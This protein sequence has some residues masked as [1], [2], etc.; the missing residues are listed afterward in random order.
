MHKSFFRILVALGALIGCATIVAQSP[1]VTASGAATPL[2][3]KALP[4]IPGKEVT[5]LTV[6]YPPGGASPAHRH[7]A[8]VFVYV[9]E[10][11]VVMQVASGQELTVSAGQT[12]HESPTDIHSVSRNASMTAPAKILVFAIKAQGAPL[13]VPVK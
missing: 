13:T 2:L 1:S 5:M 7:N 6:T 11:A 3:T 8:D 4:D 12:F 10:G 9:L